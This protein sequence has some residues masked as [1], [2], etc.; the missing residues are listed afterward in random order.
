MQWIYKF[1]QAHPKIEYN[2]FLIEE[3]HHLLKKDNPSGTA[4]TIASLLGVDPRSIKATREGDELGL[5]KIA[6]SF[7]DQEIIVQHRV[8][9]R[10]V[11]AKGA[12]FCVPELVK[13]HPG[14]Y[15]LKKFI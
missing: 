1:L 14:I 5:H 7:D 13:Q 9:N 3:V 4:L 2:A 6:L 15:E 12:L 11:F 8:L 10:A